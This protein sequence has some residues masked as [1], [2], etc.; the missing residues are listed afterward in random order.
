M[1]NRWAYR[2]ML[3]LMLL[4]F[5]LVFL[6]MYKQLVMLQRAAQQDKPAATAP[7]KP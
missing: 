6:G 7:P 3:L 4:M 1:M 5:G 2:I